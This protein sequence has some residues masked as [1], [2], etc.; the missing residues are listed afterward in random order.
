MSDATSRSSELIG[1]L[2]RYVAAERD[3]DDLLGQVRALLPRCADVEAFPVV[4]ARAWD[5]YFAVDVDTMIAIFRR[6]LALAPHDRKAK[7][8]LGGYLHAHGPDWDEEARR[9]LREANE[10]GS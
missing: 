1:L 5:E 10:E 2:D 7:G 3:D 6:W 8:T 9:L 4:A